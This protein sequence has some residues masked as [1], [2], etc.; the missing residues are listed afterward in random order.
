MSRLLLIV[1]V[2]LVGC[3]SPDQDSTEPDT[4][5]EPPETPSAE[6]SDP[7]RLYVG[8]FTRGESTSAGIYV[9]AFDETTG[10][11]SELRL[12]AKAENPSFLAL[13]PDA[14][15]LY[16]VGRPMAK[17]GAKEG[18]VLAFAIDPDSGALQLLNEQ[19]SGG[20]GP[21]HV[22]VDATGRVVLV[23]NYSGGSVA[24]YPIG[25]DGRLAE[26]SAFVQ[27]EGSSA[28]P[29]RQTRPH[30]HSIYV[31]PSNRFALSADLGIDRV[32]V[33][34]LDASTGTLTS[35][36]AATVAPG[37]GPRHLAFHPDGA[38]A[39][40]LNELNRTVTAFSFDPENG[41]MAELQTISSVPDGFTD[42]N[43]AEVRCS[44]D[45]RFLYTSNRGH[46][47]IAS[48]AIDAATGKLAATGHVSTGGHWPRN[49]TLSPS[50]RWLL[51]AN[52]KSSSI[53][54]FDI[55]PETGVPTPTG[56]TVTVSAPV[57]LRFR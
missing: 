27:H 48:F 33:Y 12:A 3:A 36:G 51:V 56:Q 54:V 32:L 40:V 4:R 25:P 38:W 39:Y 30:A 43:S 13:H 55:D 19:G 28:H 10:T 17:A 16:A 35:N 14:D 50:G 20:R 49:F 47:S 5:S 53:V 21:C 57:C 44:A 18:A 29:K 1:L 2:L 8:T 6:V 26:S 7:L 52:Q 15:F 42:G 41:E 23:A 22:T 31:D 24:A 34:G 46:D 9:L 45:G 11:L 37:S